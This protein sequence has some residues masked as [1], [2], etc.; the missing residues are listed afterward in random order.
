[1]SQKMKSYV[2]L[3]V[4]AILVVTSCI[5]TGLSESNLSVAGAGNGVAEKV[6]NIEELGGVL[7]WSSKTSKDSSELASYPGGRKDG[8][9]ILLAD[10]ENK[11]E[12]YTSVSLN[13]ATETE[14]YSSSSLDGESQETSISMKRNM[15][16]YMTNAACYYEI[17]AFIQTK[18]SAKSTRNSTIM[19]KSKVYVDETKFLIYIE[20][21]TVA[22][23]TNNAEGEKVETK[24]VNYEPVFNK[25]I[26]MTD[27][28]DGYIAEVMRSVSQRN[29]KVMSTFGVYMLQ[30]AN[31]KMFNKSGSRY[32][33]LES[34]ERG[35]IESLLSIDAVGA[36]N[37]DNDA[38]IDVNFD[39][40][41]SVPKIPKMNLF[42]T[43]NSKV[44]RE[45]Q[46]SDDSVSRY[47]YQT[48]AAENMQCR[49]F[50]INNTVVKMPR[51]KL[52]EV[53]DFGELL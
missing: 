14:T 22:S 42:Y 24:T 45:V 38:S 11:I 6:T 20:D 18:I 30:N 23:R 12:E 2:S 8:E 47:R 3:I 31:E 10:E 49:I 37:I 16:C 52:Y 1:M 9:Y 50:E 29:L 28:A 51:G 48:R 17:D 32:T 53:E 26:D 13:V 15:T 27:L 35:L 36:G 43:L 33:L 5:M 34:K 25:W 46:T 41:L 7:T 21:L 40:D 39:V 4:C 44:E 19:I